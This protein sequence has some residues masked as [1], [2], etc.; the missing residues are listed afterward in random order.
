[1]GSGLVFAIFVHLG[2]CLGGSFPSLGNVSVQVGKN[3]TAVGNL[4]YG[5]NQ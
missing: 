3:L 1:M 4:G 5:K 2:F